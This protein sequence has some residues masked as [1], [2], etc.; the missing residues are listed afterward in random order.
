MLLGGHQLH[1]VWD[2]PTRYAM[3][4]MDEWLMLFKGTTPIWL[5]V[6]NMTLIF[7]FSWECHHPN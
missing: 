1:F 2:D 5:V 7:P 3:L 6:W 4:L